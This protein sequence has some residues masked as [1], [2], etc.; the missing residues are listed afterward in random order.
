[1]RGVRTESQSDSTSAAGNNLDAFMGAIDSDGSVHDPWHITLELLRKPVISFIDTAE[2][3]AVSEK[4]WEY[5][6]SPLYQ[7]LTRHLDI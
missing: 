6:G 2:V 3:T 4:V 5:I 1:M 7:L